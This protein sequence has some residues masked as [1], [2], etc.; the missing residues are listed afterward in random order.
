MTESCPPRG[1]C[2]RPRA[3]QRWKAGRCGQIQTRWKSN[4]AAPGGAAPYTD[5]VRFHQLTIRV[6]CSGAA[7]TPVAACRAA[8]SQVAMKSSRRRSGEPFLCDLCGLCSFA[9]NP[10]FPAAPMILSTTI[11]FILPPGCGRSAP[12]ALFRGWVI[13]FSRRLSCSPVSPIWKFTKFEFVS[14]FGFRIFAYPWLWLRLRC[15]VF[16][17]PLRCSSSLSAQFAFITDP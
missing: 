9:A 5:L 7:R 16:V 3:Q 12:F 4:A 2:A 1:E 6:R 17:A 14:D 8:H 11:L 13:R 10:H 15:P